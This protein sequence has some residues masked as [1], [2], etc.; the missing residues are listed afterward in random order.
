MHKSHRLRKNEDFQLVYEEG[1]SVANRQLVLYYCRN[2]HVAHFRLGVSVSK[3]LGQAVVRNRIKRLVKE[4]VRNEA[5]HLPRGYDF[6][7]VVRRQALSL[8]Y[9]QLK[10]S[11]LHVLKKS[12]LYR[13]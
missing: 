9:E 13:P 5:K 12:K 7:V 8:N 11:F 10:N 2:P 6:I 3:K 1:R 4:V